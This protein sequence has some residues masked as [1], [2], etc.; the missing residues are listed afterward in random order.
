MEGEF[1]AEIKGEYGLQLAKGVVQGRASGQQYGEPGWPFPLRILPAL[2]Q[3][4]DPS[5]ALLLDEPETPLS[6]SI[7][8]TDDLPTNKSRKAVIP[9]CHPLSDADGFPGP[10]TSLDQNPIR[11]LE[12]ENV[13]HVRL[14]KR[15]FQDPKNYL[16]RL[17]DS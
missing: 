16:R 2:P 6:P 13:E 4:T 10:I 17:F 7:D 5:K 8:D 14:M 1:E 12:W 11:Q 3:G 9:D 15:F